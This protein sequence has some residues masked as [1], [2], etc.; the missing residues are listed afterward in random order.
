MSPVFSYIPHLYSSLNSSLWSL[1]RSRSRPLKPRPRLNTTW[2]EGR[3]SWE[4][5]KGGEPAPPSVDGRGRPC[6]VSSGRVTAPRLPEAPRGPGGRAR[7]SP[8]LH[9]QL[10]WE[11][12]GN[13]SWVS[14]GGGRGA[15]DSYYHKWFP[16]NVGLLSFPHILKKKLKVNYSNI[17]NFLKR[18]AE[19]SREKKSTIMASVITAFVR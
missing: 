9:S 18:E 4:D 8:A 7:A 14:H 13:G 17:F 3:C 5:R 6:G 2:V 16:L 10:L 15:G 12:Q 19:K 1:N 11:T